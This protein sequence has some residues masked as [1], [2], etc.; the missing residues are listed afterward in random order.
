MPSHRADWKRMTP[1]QKLQAMSARQL[2]EITV[3]EHAS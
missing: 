2:G 1:Q 3:E